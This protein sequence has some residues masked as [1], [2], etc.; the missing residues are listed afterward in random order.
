MNS[1]KGFTFIEI[2]V[3]LSVS[4]AIFMVATSLV[5]NLFSSTTKGRQ[6]QALEQ[7]KNDL[8]AEF[9][10]S[11][12][13]ADSISYIG[14]ELSVDAQKYYIK[15]GKIYKNLEALT[16]EDIEVT[17]FEVSKYLAQD[18]GSGSVGSGLSGQYF[19]NDNFTQLVFNQIDLN[20]D[21]SWGEGSPDELID[22]NTFSVR[23]TGQIEAP[24]SGEYTFFVQSDE[25]ARLWVDDVLIVDD[26]GTPGFSEKS[27]R[28]DLL[29]G[30]KYDIRLEYYENFGAASLRLLW[31]PPGSVKQIV[32]TASLYPKSGPVSMEILVEMR[33]KNS[34]STVDTLKV[35]LSPRSGNI[36]T[37]EQ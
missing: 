27:G 31:Y 26:W 3:G 35:V 34:T 14:G 2:L 18:K 6:T 5:V 20:I 32:P 13:W 24:T 4:A 16:P 36:S 29:S 33:H 25:G 15:D 23:F 30:K 17:K 22:E 21:F 37:I 11:V 1:T 19:Q 28:A 8:Q 10:N 9:G 12:R 7:V